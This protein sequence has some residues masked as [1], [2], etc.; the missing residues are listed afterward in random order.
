MP[1]AKDL[2]EFIESLSLNGVDFVVVG[3][4]AR[5]HHGAPRYT[6]DIDLLVRPSEQNA[7][8]LIRALTQFGF[9]SLGLTPADF[10][11]PERVVQLGVPPNRIDLLTSITGLTFDEVWQRRVAAELDG[12][13]VSFISR[14]DFIVNKRATGRSKDLADADAVE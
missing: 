3:A 1:L 14:Q 13:P 6:G 4:F 12:L 5:A 2:R 8:R 9:G 10:M 11:V 7:N